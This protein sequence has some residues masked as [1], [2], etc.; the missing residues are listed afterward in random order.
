MPDAFDD[1]LPPELFLEVFP[2]AIGTLAEELRALVRATIPDALERVRPGWR[3][4]GYDVPVGRAARRTTYVAWVAPE[5]RHV[6]LGF[7]NGVLLDDPAGILRGAGITKLVRWFTFRPG[8]VI[9]PAVVVPFIGAAAGIGR[10]AR[11]ERALLALARSGG[12][13][14]VAR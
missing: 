10:L 2:P 14:A 8:D 13:T 3:L 1:P 5:P 12:P 4:I 11:A 6:H 9:D 7:Q